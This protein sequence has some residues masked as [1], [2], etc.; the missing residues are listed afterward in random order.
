VSIIFGSGANFAGIC[1][2]YYGFNYLVLVFLT[3]SELKA[4]S[5]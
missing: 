4:L 2:L 3:F 5:K 1:R